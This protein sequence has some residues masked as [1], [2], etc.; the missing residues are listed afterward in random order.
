ME[1][2]KRSVVKRGSAP[3]MVLKMDASEGRS[4]VVVVDTTS[5]HVSARCPSAAAGQ[6]LEEE[7]PG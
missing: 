1:S 3:V 5:N 4:V 2:G 6:G 7:R